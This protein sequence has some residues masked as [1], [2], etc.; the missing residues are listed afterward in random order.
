M[1]MPIRKTKPVTH[2]VPEHLFD[3]F[4][5]NATDF[6][7]NARGGN[8][9]AQRAAEVRAQ[10]KD[11]GLDSLTILLE[12]T[13]GDSGQCGTVARFLAGLYNGTDFPFDMTELRGLDADL[14][15]HCI[16]VLRLDSHPDVEIHK[17]IPDGDKVFLEMLQD[18]GL[19]KRPAP[20]PPAGDHFR[21]KL[22]TIGNAPGYRDATVCVKFD[23][24]PADAPPIELYLS[25]DDSER[26]ARDLLEIHQFAWSPRNG[27][28]EPIDKEPGERRPHWL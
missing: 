4:L 10:D 14:F 27:R 16:A 3:A 11:A 18:W 19:V 2:H 9:P 23:E 25:A 12:Q 13:R 5:Q 26:L 7:Q 8:T 24:H 1:N 22:V 21:A 17:Y 15:E 28:A 6:L 20:P